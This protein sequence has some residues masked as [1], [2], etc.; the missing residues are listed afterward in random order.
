MIETFPPRFDALRNDVVAFMREQEQQRL[1][2][3]AE[4]AAL[5]QR[6]KELEAAAGGAPLWTPQ[7]VLAAGQT[8]R[9]PTGAAVAIDV[10]VPEVTF[11][12]GSVWPVVGGLVPAIYVR[13]QAHNV[14]IVGTDFHLPNAPA[15]GGQLNMRPCVRT[16]ASGTT[17]E[18]TTSGDIDGLL[19]AWPGGDRAT[20][21]RHV[22]RK[23]LRAALS[24]S[25]ADDTNILHT[26]APDSVTENLI[27]WSP[28]S[29]VVGKRG[30]VAFCRIGQKGNKS[31]I[32]FRHIDGGLAIY[33]EFTTDEHGTAIGVGDK[34]ANDGDGDHG[35]VSVRII[36]NTFHESRVHIHGG[37][38]ELYV[39]D[40]RFLWTRQGVNVAIYASADNRLRNLR[41]RNNRGPRPQPG[42]ETRPDGST[43]P[44]PVKPLFDKGGEIQGLDDD[45]S[46]G[47]V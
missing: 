36:G 13:E 16:L 40:N 28:R 10:R 27:R 23:P 45:G 31:V 9:L 37:S 30:V 47:W 43:R 32:D 8:Y 18:S 7:T 42:V 11:V 2:L 24:F 21:F 17:L 25:S 38:R 35:A 41:L 3:A 15:G 1:A 33:N 29:G 39:E 6:V 19:E 46:T 4:K 20:V 22:A 12:G 34:D 26:I 44:I 5:Q 14:R